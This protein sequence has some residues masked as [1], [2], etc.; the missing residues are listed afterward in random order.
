MSRALALLV[1][2]AGVALAGGSLLLRRSEDPQLYE[3]GV[4][5][6][7]WQTV[8]TIGGV[9]VQV[10]GFVL[11]WSAG[12]SIDDDG[13]PMCY[14]PADW[15]ALRGRTPL[16]RDSPESAVD[17]WKPGPG[18]SIGDVKTWAGVVPG[19]GNLPLVQGPGDPAPGF[20]ISTT[21]LQDG[22][23]APSDPRRYANA[24]EVPF[25]SMPSGLFAQGARLGDVCAVEYRGAVA[26]AEVADIGPAHKIG[27]GSPALARLL[28]IPDDP[29]RGGT[30]SGVTAYLFTGS[31][32]HMP[33]TVDQ[34]NGIAGTLYQELR[35]SGPL[36]V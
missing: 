18:R 12:L 2:L 3:P 36:V 23:Y 35:R 34:I 28:G 27:E 14:H 16:G 19:P 33:L 29:R 21:A 17:S 31:G 11:A 4:P 7:D 25:I 6:A 22:Q 15:G 24:Q 9:R 32:H 1:S 10:A 5:L 26:F 13:D 8:D 20:W 30:S